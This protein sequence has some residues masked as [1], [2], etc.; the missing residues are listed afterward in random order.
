MGYERNPGHGQPNV[1][2]TQLLATLMLRG[3]FVG[4]AGALLFLVGRSMVNDLLEEVR[5]GIL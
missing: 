1:E 2:A 5:A 3:A 4:A